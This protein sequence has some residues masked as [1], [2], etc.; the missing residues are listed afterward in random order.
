[1]CG[2]MKV[3]REYDWHLLRLLRYADL[4]LCVERVLS[5]FRVGAIGFMD[6]LKESKNLSKQ[7]LVI[8]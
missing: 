2:L 1:M 8:Y 5:R 7:L 4:R 3:V 6:A